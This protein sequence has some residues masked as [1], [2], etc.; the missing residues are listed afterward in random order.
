M[1]KLQSINLCKLIE[2]SEFPVVEKKFQM[3]LKKFMVNIPR[4]LRL[5]AIEKLAK[6]G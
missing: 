2:I 5:T 4:L 6:R 3:A 1:L